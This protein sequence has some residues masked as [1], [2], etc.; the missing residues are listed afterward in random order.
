MIRIG[1][2]NYLFRKEYKIYFDT[3]N[4]FF[5]INI[6]RY[7]GPYIRVNILKKRKHH[8]TEDKFINNKIHIIKGI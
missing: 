1:K 6:G 8:Y 3:S 7:S 5:M 2:R 4:I